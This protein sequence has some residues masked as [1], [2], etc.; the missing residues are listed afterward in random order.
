V[1]R[2]IA[3]LTV[4]LAV[5]LWMVRDVRLADPPRRDAEQPSLSA[6]A[7]PAPAAYAPP[8]SRDPFRF[9]DEASVALP[10]PALVDRQ[11]AT[12]A[13]SF[14][15]PPARLSG[16]VRRAGRVLAV[17][18]VPGGALVLGVGEEIDGY[19]VLSIDEEIGVRVR[20]PDG[21]ELELPLLP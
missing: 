18:S 1:K 14:A 13:S 7:P 12:A 16:F 5:V 21:R 9:A 17:L 10:E 19:R 15:P 3:P 11:P 20:T 2:L 6:S 8:L 4:A